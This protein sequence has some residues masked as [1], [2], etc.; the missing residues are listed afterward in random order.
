[1]TKDELQVI[2]LIADDCAA[3]G[4]SYELHQLQAFFC[5]R[6]FGVLHRQAGEI[7]DALH[8]EEAAERIMETLREDL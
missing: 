3:L 8:H 4:E 7:E 2:E 5:N 1:M 6:H